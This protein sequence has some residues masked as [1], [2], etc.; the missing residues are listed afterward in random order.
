MT[1]EIYDLLWQLRGHHETKVFTYIAVR[2]RNG[3]VK[4]HAIPLPFRV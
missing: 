2:T 1:R 4:G 3:R